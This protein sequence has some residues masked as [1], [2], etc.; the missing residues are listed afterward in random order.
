MSA[1]RIAFQKNCTIMSPQSK[2]ALSPATAFMNNTT[3]MSIDQKR[4]SESHSKPRSSDDAESDNT[5]TRDDTRNHSSIQSM[6][7]KETSQLNQN[8][9]EILKKALIETLVHNDKVRIG[10]S[11]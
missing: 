6:L 11:F 7:R 2:P 1:L 8:Q 4:L 5:A 10:T 3:M 9:I